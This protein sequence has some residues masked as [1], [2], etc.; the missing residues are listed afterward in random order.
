MPGNQE[1]RFHF[2]AK[3]VV[4]GKG[5]MVPGISV[6]DHCLN[7]GCVAEALRALAPVTLQRLL[8]PGAVTLAALHDSGKIS[9][10]F[11]RKCDWWRGKFERA[12]LS[13]EWGQREKKH[14][15]V[16]HAI[17][18]KWLEKERAGYAIAAGGHHGFFVHNDHQPAIGEG[19]RWLAAEL[20]DALFAPNREK[21]RAAVASVFKQDLPALPLTR[22]DE[23]L[24]VFLTG[25]MTF[26][27]W[28]GSNEIF[29]PL[30]EESFF[31]PLA[32]D[33]AARLG[34]ERAGKI[35]NWLRWGR[36]KVAVDRSFEQLFPFPSNELQDAL[37]G[38]AARP[39]LFIVEAPMGGGKTE[40][41]LAQPIGA[42][43]PTRAS[44]VYI[45]RCLRN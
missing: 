33:E 15:A 1:E 36:T 3:T 26:A 25:F 18:G 7:V 12:R 44:A 37:E 23:A 29:F 13:A 38:L 11:Q 41:A 16:S 2:W 8:P 9:P 35:M 14:A 10:G 40:A 43:Q 31:A 4:N 21:L 32:L 45:L 30:D 22:K 17:L 19:G 34:R 6:R 42:G 39:G 5:E 24:I 27:D 20:C 28:L